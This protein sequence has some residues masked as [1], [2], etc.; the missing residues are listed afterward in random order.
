MVKSLLLIASASASALGK[1][2][3]LAF[4]SLIR[5]SFK[6][7]GVFEHVRN[8]DEADVTASDKNLV[9]MELLSI[10]SGHV[11]VIQSHVHCILSFHQ[12]AAIELSALELH[13]DDMVFSFVQKLDWH[14][15]THFTSL[16]F[17]N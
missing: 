13:C 7:G 17:I 9:K 5:D 1:Q 6:H 4:F 8:N 11:N 14:S 10:A 2:S 12:I 16:K 15:D 3:I